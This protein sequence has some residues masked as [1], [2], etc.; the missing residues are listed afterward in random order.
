MRR[1]LTRR[2]NVVLLTL[3][4]LLL[5]AAGYWAGRP[6]AV[7]AVAAVISDPVAERFAALDAEYKRTY[8]SKTREEQMHADAAHRLEIAKLTP[9]QQK[10]YRR[11]EME[12]SLRR[13]DEK[14]L[15]YHAMTP[16]QKR[17]LLDEEIDEDE[18]AIKRTEALQAARKAAGGPSP[19]TVP[20][21]PREP[22]PKKATT[23]SP[24]SPEIRAIQINFIRDRRARRIERGLPLR[25]D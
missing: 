1:F 21:P 9:D 12:A 5:G 6:V 24:V 13:F 25:G 18:A 7:A 15:R 8:H 4:L 23:V 10:T 14:L 22:G 2:R 16:E 3:L 20:R 19:K 11:A 17:A